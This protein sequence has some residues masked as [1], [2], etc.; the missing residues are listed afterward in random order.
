MRVLR[1]NRAPRCRREAWAA[2]RRSTAGDRSSRVF[3]IPVWGGMC[4]PGFSNENIDGERFG[5]LGSGT[6]RSA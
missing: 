6:L 3:T 4:A 5:T 2:G 1:P